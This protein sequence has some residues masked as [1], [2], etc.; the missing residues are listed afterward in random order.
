M[1]DSAYDC[2][3]MLSSFSG[4]DNRDKTMVKR[5]DLDFF[6]YM[7]Q[8]IKGLKIGVIKELMEC[9][10]EILAATEEVIKFYKDS[11]AIIE[12]ISMPYLKYGT[13]T[14]KAFAT[15]QGAI[16][17]NEFTGLNFD[18]KS[19]YHD[20]ETDEA[21]IK[22]R[23]EAFGLEVKKRILT[24]VHSL[25]AGHFQKAVQMKNLIKQGYIDAFKKCDII[26][27]PTTSTTA[28]SVNSTSSPVDNC[29]VGANLAK[30]PSLS[31]PAGLDC[32]GM[33]IGVCVIGNYFQE[34]RMLALADLFQR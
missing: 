27:N 20:L 12:E 30:L 17:M 25:K 2:A 10:P 28:F 8:N 33:P 9:Q 26:I 29:T 34:A 31:M 5:D 15:A 19:K 16:N 11:G 21:I 6:K 23:G 24:G 14:Y 7:G 18:Y 1:A 22:S 4:Y 13:V 32:S 3:M